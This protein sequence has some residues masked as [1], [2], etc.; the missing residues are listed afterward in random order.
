MCEQHLT[1]EE[2]A[3]RPTDIVGL[4]DEIVV[5]VTNRRIYAEAHPR[6]TSSI[7]ALAASIATLMGQMGTTRLEIGSAEGFLFHDHRPLL[8]ATLSAKRLIDQ[9][10]G[11]R[12]GGLTIDARVSKDQLRTLVAYLA[13]GCKGA[14]DFEEA[15]QA[16]ASRGCG[17]VQFLPPY[18]N[19]GGG[20]GNGSASKYD[21]VLDGA[22]PEVKSFDLGLE[23]NV[24]SRLYQDVV[25][26]MQDAMMKSCRSEHLDL[27]AAA[28]HVE[29]ILERLTADAKSL[30]S[31]ARYELYDEFTFG[32][33]IRVCLIALDF[34]RHLTNDV[35]TLQRIGTAALLH[36]IGKAWVPFEVLHST[37][38][39][40][41]EE[42]REMSLHAVYGGQILLDSPKPDPLAVSVAFS[43]HQTPDGGGYPRSIRSPR[44]SVPTMIVKL[45]DVF[46]ALTAVRPYK[47]RMSPARAFRIMMSM[48]G[49]FDP[50]LLR[51]FIEVIGVY[52]VGSRVRLSN[53]DVARVEAQT[54]SLLK[55]VV[56]TETSASGEPLFE[57][58]V[59]TIDLSRDRSR[60]PLTVE[61]MLLE[62]E[63]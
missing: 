56:R 36:D 49:H 59:L 63:L 13:S 48:E 47:P 16:L 4:V 35:P 6:V 51:R 7:D 19:D 25:T 62:A 33:S 12:S 17:T 2:R 37:T 40:S 27:T 55:P 23:L 43:H 20:N 24:S 18:T 34:A 52:P 8:G 41:P 11:L 26:V 46:E 45:S 58:D 14:E 57:E 30:M 22:L 61:D 31:L 29:S 1:E 32:H 38:L 50:A 42:R 3:S 28:G 21:V 60:T 44:V 10:A 39:L 5:S 15:N 9:L 54:D 53:G